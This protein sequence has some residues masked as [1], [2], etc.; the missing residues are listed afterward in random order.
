MTLSPKTK[1]FLSSAAVTVG[2]A[3]L[4]TL[5]VYVTKVHPELQVI[6]TSMIAGLMLSL[7]SW[8]H[9]DEVKAEVAAKVTE[10][11]GREAL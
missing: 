1:K 11:V 3:A 5:N 6:A 9:D 7:K 4:G 10:A 8:G 2:V